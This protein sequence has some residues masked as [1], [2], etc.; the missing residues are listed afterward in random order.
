MKNAKMKNARLITTL[1]LAGGVLLSACAPMSSPTPIPPTNTPNA[2][3]PI[4]NTGW[5]LETLNGQPVLSGKGITLNFADGKLAGTDGC[6][7]YNG[8]Y[9]TNGS[10]LTVNK[11]VAST[12]MACGDSIMQQA[13]AYTNAL[14]QAA[15]YKA[16]G[17]TLTLFD[18]AG[19][20]LAIFAAQS[21]ELGS[22]SWV[23]T[24]YNNGKQAVVSVLADTKMTL[25]FSADGK[26]SGSAG[27][28]TYGGS[29]EA[30]SASGSIKL[31][32][33]FA[34]EKACVK[35]EGIMG[36]EAQYLKAL[37][38]AAAYI[39]DAGQLMIRDAT[40]AMV[41]TFQKAQ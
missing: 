40:G 3:T 41:A 38:N 8:T 7:F 31:S 12:L 25:A 34:T 37:G 19:K 28:N 13:Q 21:N 33:L 10:A 26:M 18:A 17:K 9:T 15:S 16:E 30:S 24:G 4:N 27:C 29:Y 39:I 35:P 6:N 20:N 1:A 2:T 11:N 5:T 14:T 23:V 32:Q 22:T 36:Q